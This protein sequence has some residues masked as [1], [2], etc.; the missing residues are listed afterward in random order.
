MS[1]KIRKI[2]IPAIC[3][4]F[5]ILGI[6]GYFFNKIDS[7]FL[8]SIEEENNLLHSRISG[9]V[10]DKKNYID[11]IISKKHEIN[12]LNNELIDLDKKHI[13]T[14]IELIKYKKLNQLKDFEDCKKN[15]SKL[16]INFN[17]VSNDNDYLKIKLDLT[18]KIISE[19]DSQ[20]TDL[21][22]VISIDDKQIKDLSKS[23]EELYKKS[24]NEM[25]KIIKKNKKIKTF[26]VIGLSAL[27]ILNLIK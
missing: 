3:V 23:Y 2:V 4:I 26:S 19:K 10:L 17:S 11:S 13:E 14:K 27:I 16:E 22:S 20:I 24:E 6:W 18:N 7:N 8:K 12:R 9:Y 21:N 5:F 1:G 25:K 15:F